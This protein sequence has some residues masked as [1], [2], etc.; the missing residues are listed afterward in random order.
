[1]GKSEGGMSKS[2]GGMSKSEGD[3][4]KTAMRLFR[5][6]YLNCRTEVVGCRGGVDLV[7]PRLRPEG[8]PYGV[9]ESYYF[10]VSSSYP[11]AM[12]EETPQGRKRRAKREALRAVEEA[13]GRSIAR[14]GGGQGGRG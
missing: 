2:E 10:D 12:M 9:G 6:R 14:R 7:D 11:A 3:A 8:V 1:M 5:A 13:S 4:G